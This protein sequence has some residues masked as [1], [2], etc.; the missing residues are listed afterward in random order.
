MNSSVLAQDAFCVTRTAGSMEDQDY[1]VRFALVRGNEY[2]RIVRK[3]I[4]KD[5]KR[6]LDVTCHL[7]K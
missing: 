7:N 4:Y 1:I 2:V 5:N 3:N 6:M